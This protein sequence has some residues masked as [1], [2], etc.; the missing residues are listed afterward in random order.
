MYLFFLSLPERFGPRYG[1]AEVRA[2][3]EKHARSQDPLFDETKV[4]SKGGYI[5]W[6]AYY[7]TGKGISIHVTSSADF[8]GRDGWTSVDVYIEGKRCDC[9]RYRL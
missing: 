4:K 2:A 6:D 9:C 7:D 3:Y 5:D 1:L 8:N